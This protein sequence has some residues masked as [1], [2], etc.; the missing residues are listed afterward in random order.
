M[1]H[2]LPLVSTALALAGCA[3]PTVVCRDTPADDLVRPRPGRTTW[4]RACDRRAWAD[5]R[6]EA[7]GPDSLR[8][9]VGDEQVALSLRTDVREV[10][11]VPR[12]SAALPVAVGLGTLALGTLAVL[13]SPSTCRNASDRLACD[14]FETGFRMLLPVIGSASVSAG[15]AT[16]GLQRS[17]PAYVHRYTCPAPSPQE[18]KGAGQ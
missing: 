18:D 12:N 9:H 10:S 6:L 8:L 16:A 15:V 14:V 7:L 5:P 3:P 17:R 2:V 11:F 4:V 1:R 13:A